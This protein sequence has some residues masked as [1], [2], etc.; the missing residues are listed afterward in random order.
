[1]PSE[2]KTGIVLIMQCPLSSNQIPQKNQKQQEK[3]DQTTQKKKVY[4]EYCPAAK[5]SV[6]LK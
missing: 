2:L 1:M 6:C 3:K 5:L 4:N